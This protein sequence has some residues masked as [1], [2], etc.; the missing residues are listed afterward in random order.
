MPQTEQQ[1]SPS[2]S[3]SLWTF[4]SEFTDITQVPRHVLQASDHCRPNIHIPPVYIY[5]YPPKHQL[6]PRWVPVLL[7]SLFTCPPGADYSPGGHV[8]D[9]ASVADHPITAWMGW[10][11]VGGGWGVH[12]NRLRDPEPI[13]ITSRPS[14]RNKGGIY[15]LQGRSNSP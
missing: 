8:G 10:V 14:L 7:L 4:P 15:C 11:W 1:A 2:N 9:S 5:I 13:A 3:T 12:S 6:S